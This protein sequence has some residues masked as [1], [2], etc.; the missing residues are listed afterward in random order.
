ML[1]WLC[2]I[3]AAIYFLVYPNILLVPEEY[4]QGYLSLQDNTFNKGIII[5]REEYE[6]NSLFNHKKLQR[7]N[8]LV[9]GKVLQYWAANPAVYEETEQ[10]NLVAFEARG[11]VIFLAASLTDPP[12]IVSMVNY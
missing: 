9:N 3:A 6:V 10:G 2:L 1:R 4:R 5:S 11:K 7:V 12:P 8:I